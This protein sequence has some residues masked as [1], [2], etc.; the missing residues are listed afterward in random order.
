[1]TGSKVVRVTAGDLDGTFGPD[2]G[3]RMV[4]AFLPGDGKGI[5]DIISLRPL[6]TRRAEQVAV[7]DVYR[8][9]LKCRV[10]R[11]LLE[12]ARDRKSRKAERLARQRQERAEKKLFE[13]K[14][15]E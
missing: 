5:P 9:A 14:D 7:V 6:R 1:M 12:K 10:N 13:R 2:R 11:E 15:L 3:R 4:V 8:W